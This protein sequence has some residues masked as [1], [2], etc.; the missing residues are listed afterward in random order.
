MTITPALLDEIDAA[1][2]PVS[3][4][5]NHLSANG[6]RNRARQQSEDRTHRIGQ[7]HSVTYIDLACRGTVD[8]K[9]VHT[10]RSKMDLAA[11]LAGDAWRE[12]VV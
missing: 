4:W 11:A 8:E 1:L 5:L 9:W 12:W 2:E 3:G 10:I 6:P 7:K